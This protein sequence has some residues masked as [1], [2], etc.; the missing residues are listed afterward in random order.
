MPRDSSEI[1]RGNGLV[2]QN[3]VGR[4][5]SS[6]LSRSSRSKQTIASVAEPR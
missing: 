5:T 1:V 6:L 2:R 4:L 3:Q